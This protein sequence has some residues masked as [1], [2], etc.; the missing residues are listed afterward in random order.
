MFYVSSNAQAK[1]LCNPPV[2]P[3]IIERMKEKDE[4]I[5]HSHRHEPLGQL[6]L[7]STNGVPFFLSSLL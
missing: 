4:A 1:E 3:P 6:R 2:Q 7:H 5:Y